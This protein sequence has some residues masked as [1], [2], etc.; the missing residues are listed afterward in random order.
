MFDAVRSEDRR[1]KVPHWR[2]SWQYHTCV[3]GKND[4]AEEKGE[5]KNKIIV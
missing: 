1:E 2:E 5:E 4:T 3:A